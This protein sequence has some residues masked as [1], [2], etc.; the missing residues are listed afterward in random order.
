MQQR[1]RQARKPKTSPKV[2]SNV[3]VSDYGEA[4]V[5]HSVLPRQA[6]VHGSAQRAP[7]LLAHHADRQA[8]VPLL[9]LPVQRA[10]PHCLSSNT[11][12]QRLGSAL[13]DFPREDFAGVLHPS[14]GDVHPQDFIG[15]L[16]T[17]RENGTQAMGNFIF[18]SLLD[19]TQQLFVSGN[20]VNTSE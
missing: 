7:Q 1:C 8:D 5:H 15:S 12:D 14:Q 13:L 19:L 20:D 10:L 11:C 3:C 6:Q 4:G 18:Y 16:K 17:T 2:S 9:H